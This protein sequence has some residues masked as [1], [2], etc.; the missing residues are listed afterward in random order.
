MSSP[1]HPVLRSLANGFHRAVS[2]SPVCS[3]LYLNAAGFL[4]RNTPVF[5]LKEAVIQAI[6][7][8]RWP[9][10]CFGPRN[11]SVCRGTSFNLIPHH[12]EFDF[13]AVFSRTLEYE[14]EVFEI[15]SNRINLYDAVVEVGANVGVF[16]IF[17]GKRLATLDREGIVLSFEPS[18]EAFSRLQRNLAIN[19]I[20]NVTPFNCAVGKQDG[21]VAFYEPR[22]HLT[23]G[24]FSK[25]FAALFSSD[26]RESVVPCVSGE[27]IAGLLDGHH[28]VLFKIDAEGAERLVLEGFGKLI[29]T[30]RPDIVLEVLDRYTD[31]LNA[32]SSLRDSYRFFNIVPGGARERPR[33]EATEHRDYLLVH[34]SRSAGD[35]VLHQ[36]VD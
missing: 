19:G 15:L 30:E 1:R 20:E 11:V 3:R 22:G 7:S 23:N 16:S 26:V 5:P 27:R 33:L 36:F 2:L 35:P 24:S 25:D 32:L 21:F 13:R 10:V 12:G 8:A 9:Q 4:L 18:R 29:E 28:R 6:S 31:D 17:F 14:R 34:K